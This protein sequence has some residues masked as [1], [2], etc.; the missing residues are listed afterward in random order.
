MP[1]LTKKGLIAGL[2]IIFAAGILI[3]RA[4]TIQVIEVDSEA[5][6]FET[7]NLEEQ[8]AQILSEIA[9]SVS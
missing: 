4:M 8:R 7:K 9:G 3:G 1:E 5:K 2:A 6:T